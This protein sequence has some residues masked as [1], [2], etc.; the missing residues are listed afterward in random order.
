MKNV[1]IT[2]GI[3]RTTY[4]YHPIEYVLNFKFQG[5]DV[6]AKLTTTNLSNFIYGTELEPYYVQT[7][8]D[9]LS[10][11]EN[12]FNNDEFCEKVCDYCKN[13]W[14]NF[15]QKTQIKPIYDYLGE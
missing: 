10:S 14:E 8:S 1:E 6:L 11:F 4:D 3:V 13:L 2:S 9:L 12:E 5:E 15:C 7:P